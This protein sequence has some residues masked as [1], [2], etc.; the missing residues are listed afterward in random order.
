MKPDGAADGPSSSAS[1]SERRVP[2]LCEASSLK[3]IFGFEPWLF[4]S[5]V[6]GSALGAPALAPVLDATYSSSKS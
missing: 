1:S 2:P 4:R 5:G 6:P 3:A